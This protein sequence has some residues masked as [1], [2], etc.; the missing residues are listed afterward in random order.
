[1]VTKDEWLRSAMSDDR[2]VADLLL[3]LRHPHSPSPSFS[4]SSFARSSSSLLPPPRW[5]IRLPRTRMAYRCDG[6]PSCSPEK[7]PDSARNSPTTPLAWSTG[8]G[9]GTGDGGVSSSGTTNGFDEPALPVFRSSDS[10]SE[11]VVADDPGTTDANKSKRKKTFA[12]LKEEEAELLKE[13]VYLEEEIATLRM[14]FKERAATNENLK[15]MKLGFDLNA[16]NG[17]TMAV[18]EKEGTASSLEK[19]TALTHRTPPLSQDARWTVGS[20]SCQVS[21]PGEE[22]DG[23]FILPD[24]NMTPSE[25]DFPSEVLHGMAGSMEA[26]QVT[27]S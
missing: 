19:D 1:M 16:A 13:R 15:R 9:G 10:R 3:R 23:G 7:K 21:L 18:D 6:A 22:P 17:S 11:V 24:L 20:S 12:E 14:T 5:G 8:G 25:N 26:I 27:A 2:M 4:S